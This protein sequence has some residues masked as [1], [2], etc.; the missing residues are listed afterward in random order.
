MITSSESS[1][2][3]QV[4]QFHQSDSSFNC[5]EAFVS[6][7]TGHSILDQRPVLNVLIGP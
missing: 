1:L 7:W 4:K 6:P 5:A 2:M 3:P